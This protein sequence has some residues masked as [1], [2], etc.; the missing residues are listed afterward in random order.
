MFSWL[1]TTLSEEMELLKNPSPYTPS[2]Y[3]FISSGA[4]RRHLLYPEGHLFIG[5]FPLFSMFYVYI[6]LQ[7]GLACKQVTASTATISY[8]S[9]YFCLYSFLISWLPTLSP[10]I[11]QVNTEQETRIK[12]TP[13]P[14]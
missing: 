8:I 3:L 14:T 2:V 10:V 11:S 6:C 7:V 4:C 1:P 9:M 5:H 12:S 13:L